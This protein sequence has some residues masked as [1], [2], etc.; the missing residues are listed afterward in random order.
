M[1][2]RAAISLTIF[3]MLLSLFPR[4]GAEQNASPPVSQEKLTLE[5]AYMCEGV[6]GNSPYNQ[7]VVFSAGLGRVFCFTQF[8][9]VPENT[10]V[11]HN[12]Y[13]KDK[14]HF[15]KKLA[16]RKPQWTTF[17]TISIRVNDKG[18]WRVEIL[19]S[20]ERRLR[21]LRFSIVD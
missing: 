8:N 1:K 20:G 3:L 10:F 2:H 6:E 5:R 12:W 7:A 21:T 14:L 15:S 4:A 9:P 11:F 17:S 19:D 13:L 16:L 18:P